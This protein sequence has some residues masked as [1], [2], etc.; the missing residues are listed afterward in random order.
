MKAILK[1]LFIV[2][3]L[4]SSAGVI[5]ADEY[6]DKMYSEGLELM[7]REKYSQAIVKFKAAAE[8]D[9][10]LSGNCTA[11]IK[12]CNRFI[13]SKQEPKQKA[14]LGVDK[15]I[16]KISAIG[17]N[18]NV[19]VSN[20]KVWTVTSNAD[21][22]EVQQKNN[23]FSVICAP[24]ESIIERK[25]VVE[26]RS[27]DE[28]QITEIIQAAAAE[29]L[30][31]TTGELSFSTKGNEEEITVFTNTKW[32]FS[33]SPYWCE[34]SK[35][36]NKLKIKATPNNTSKERNGSILINSVSKTLTINITQNAESEVLDVSKKAV[37]FGYYGGKDEIT[38]YSNTE[39]WMIEK[40]P[41][42]CIASKKNESSLTIECLNNSAVKQRTGSILIKT[43]NQT[44]A[45]KIDQ[46]QG[47]PDNPIPV[48]PVGPA[49]ATYRDNLIGG[50]DVSFGITAGAVF[51]SFATSA[52]S[53]YLGSAV[54]YGYDADNEKTN[55]SSEV[56]FSIGL[57]ADIRLVNNL[58]LQTGI[59]YTTI[60]V[61]NKFS[62]EFTENFDYGTNPKT[63]VEGQAF[64]EFTEKYTLN[65]LEIPFIL[66]YRFKLSEKTNW[67]INAGPY[68]G[69]G[70]SGKCKVEGSTDEPSLVEYYSN[71]DRPT[72][73]TY[74]R[75][76]TVNGEFDLFGTTGSSTENY[77][78]GDKPSYDYEYTFKESPFKK[79]NAGIS[80]G[81]SIEFSGFNLGVSYDIGL[82][83]I[84]NEDYWK[85]ER[86][87]VTDYSGTERMEDYSHKIH[88]FQIKLA[89]IFRW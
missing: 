27:G 13:N 49:A 77:T 51:P 89:Y 70:L 71:N 60:N 2:F 63:Y 59:N 7:T 21:W 14:N 57:L 80:L 66:S 1:S 75:N 24:N 4:I 72:G 22:C 36:G 33:N 43:G 83:N 46:A 17:G 31:V 16:I 19:L 85:T 26:V 64:D 28:V 35:I 39:N 44:V 74:E 30:R 45:V 9:D 29:F 15:K 81:T 37:S 52:S 6:C 5:T 79:L 18:D 32:D 67:Q 84:A 65:Y 87:A 62:G 42:W 76:W 73:E 23:T 20:G 53:D 54:N 69:Y 34:I 12:E 25:A 61:K 41:E 47:I 86:F 56:G 8:C 50:R 38:V 88:K 68:I 10:N 82:T 58:Y 3:F 40:F 55:Y 78:T 48:G 11:Q